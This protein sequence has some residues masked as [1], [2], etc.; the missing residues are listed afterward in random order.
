MAQMMVTKQIAKALSKAGYDEDKDIGHIPI[1]TKYFHCSMDFD[2]Y[3]IGGEEKED[4]WWMLAIARHAGSPDKWE[5]GFFNLPELSEECKTGFLNL[6]REYAWKP[7]FKTV[8]DVL[9]K[10]YIKKFTK[11]FRLMMSVPAL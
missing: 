2:A 6:E 8:A 11:Q 9:P 7:G 3:V 10:K 5:L 1:V 4:G